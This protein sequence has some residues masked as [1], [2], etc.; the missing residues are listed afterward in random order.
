MVSELKNK[1][2]MTVTGLING[3][4]LGHCQCHEHLF[5][6][7]GKPFEINPVL[8]IDNLQ[9]IERELYNSKKYGGEKLG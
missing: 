4:N 1:K 9:L 7:K 8:W 6:R 3:Y 5:I 2:I